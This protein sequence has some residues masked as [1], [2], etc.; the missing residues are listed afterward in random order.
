VG[1]EI[2]GIEARLVAYA[3]ILSGGV[4][5]SIFLLLA[6]GIKNLLGQKVM[7]MMIK[8]TALVLTA[9]AA[10]IIFT[11]IKAFLFT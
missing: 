7:T 6:D 9:L 4:T 5:V 2:T 11:G 8:L 1:T 10:Q 3:A